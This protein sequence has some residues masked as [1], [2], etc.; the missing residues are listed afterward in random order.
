[1]RPS[2]DILVIDGWIPDYALVEGWKEFQHGHYSTLLTVGGPF[3]TGF[4]LNP[5]DDY[6][7]LAAFKLREYIGAGFRCS[8]S[9]ARWRNGTGLLRAR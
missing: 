8:L 4:D 3:R 1:M 7:D 5:D 2:A 9:A 6:A